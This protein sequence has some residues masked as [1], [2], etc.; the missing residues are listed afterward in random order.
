MAKL[1]TAYFCQECG[2][3]YVKWQG[4]CSG[5]G[6]WNTLVEEIVEKTATGSVKPSSLN[7]KT[8]PKLL[9]QIDLDSQPRFATPDLEMNRVLGSVS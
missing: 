9:T 7:A 2:T 4:Q 8:E 3:Q 5:C 6:A 1:K